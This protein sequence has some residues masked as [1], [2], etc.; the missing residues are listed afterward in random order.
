MVKSVFVR[1]IRRTGQISGPTT[2]T[3]TEM[4][5]GSS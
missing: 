2:D 5:S 4:M 1:Y 3:E